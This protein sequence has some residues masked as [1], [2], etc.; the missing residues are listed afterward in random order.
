VVSSVN[1]HYAAKMQKDAFGALMRVH[2]Q[3]RKL[4]QQQLTEALAKVGIQIDTSGITRLEKG[5]REPRLHEALGIA[6][7]LNFSLDRLDEFGSQGRYHGALA[8]LEQHMQTAR[9]ALSELIAYAG[10]NYDVLMSREHIG[11]G[12][13]FPAPGQVGSDGLVYDGHPDGFPSPGFVPAETTNW[14]IDTLAD[15]AEWDD[16]RSSVSSVDVDQWRDSG[17][18]RWLLRAAA[19]LA[20]RLLAVVQLDLIQNVPAPTLPDADAPDA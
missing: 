18:P 9:R 13:G 3:D 2:R 4:T 8:G 16:L 12:A 17:S 1:Q 7:V 19:D 11:Q 20:E 6:A 10:S 5:Q 15:P 14:L